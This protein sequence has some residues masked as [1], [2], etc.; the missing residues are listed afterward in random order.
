M[1]HL[2]AVPETHTLSACA[3]TGLKPPGWD[4]SVWEFDRTVSVLQ[5]TDR[6]TP[7]ARPRSRSL[8]VTR[9]GG[10][11]GHPPSRNLATGS[12]VS[13]VQVEPSTMEDP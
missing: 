5:R 2:R 4:G 1:I 3:C 6:D 10:D 13:P 7:G 8:S 9:W 12:S 11:G